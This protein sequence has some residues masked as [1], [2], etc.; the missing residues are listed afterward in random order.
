VKRLKQAARQIAIGPARALG[1]LGFTPN[2]LT[3]IGSLLTACVGIL[4]AQGWFVAA[5]LCLWLFAATDTLDGA[6]ARATDRV[7]VFGAFL[8][9]VCDRYAEAGVFLGI[10]WWYQSTGDRLGM[11]LTYVAAIGS[12]MVS[13]ARARAE[14][15]GLHAEVGW[16]QRP[17]RIIV[18]GIGLLLTNWLP[19]ALLVVLVVLA[20][21]TNLT[22]IQRVIHVARLTRAT[23]DPGLSA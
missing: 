6:L 19:V 11:V 4:V 21:L 1:R 15:I 9:S 13:Y 3:V 17:E 5:A 16:F 12:L 22:V 18:L 8:D 2:M 10:L 23:R 14:G 7:T 20:V